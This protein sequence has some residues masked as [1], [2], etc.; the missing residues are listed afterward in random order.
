MGPGTPLPIIELFTLTI[1]TMPD[2]LFVKNSSLN[3]SKSSY[4]SEQGDIERW[5][6]G[7]DK[8]KMTKE[9]L[10]ATKKLRKNLKKQM[11]R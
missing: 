9:I 3:L 8:K 10:Q 2:P 4:I 6:G 1:G 5:I 7:L 11:L